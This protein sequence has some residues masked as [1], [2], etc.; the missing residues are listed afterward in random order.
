[1][2][3]VANKQ[4]LSYVETLG[5]RLNMLESEHIK[6]NLV[7]QAIDDIIVINTC[8]VTAQAE[9]SSRKAVRKVIKHNPNARVVVTGCSAQLNPDTYN[10]IKGVTAVLGNKDKLLADSYANL[11]SKVSDIMVDHEAMP[12]FVDD[13]TDNSRAFVEIQQGCNHR[14]TFCIIPYGRGNS[15]S[16]PPSLIIANIKKLVEENN[17]NEVVLTGV[18]ITSYGEDLPTT[19]AK[20][21]RL[22]TLVLKI[23]HNVPALQRLRLSSVDLAEID[24]DLWQAIADEPRLMPHFH[25]SLQHGHDLILKRM[26]RR[27]SMEDIYHFCQQARQLRPNVVFGADV[28]VGFP[29]ETADHF[30]TTI[31]VLRENNIPLIH[32]FS[33]SP[34]EGTPAKKMPQ[35]HASIIKQRMQIMQATTKE[36]KQNIYNASIGQQVN[37]LL[38]KH[39]TGYSEQYLACKINNDHSY[40]TGSVVQGY[41]SGYVNGFLQVEVI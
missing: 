9:A 25:I 8:A 15:R 31:K 17:F 20:P 19:T 1:M 5:C 23:L 26:K 7:K 11:N 18:D 3:K 27:H 21:L 10:N 38:E 37:I 28:I 39:N 2:A 41:V 24:Q 4:N 40:S 29:T 36:L 22:G 35:V 34:R 14:C 33:Y 16:I 6:A 32:S 12:T 13:F 30:A